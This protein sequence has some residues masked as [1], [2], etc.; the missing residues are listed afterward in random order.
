MTHEQCCNVV[1]R[2]LFAVRVEYESGKVV[3]T[4]GL[5]PETNF[6]LMPKHN[7]YKLVGGEL[8]RSK[9]KR[10]FLRRSPTPG[11]P[12]FEVKL[13]EKS[14]MPLGGDLALVHT[15]AGG[16]VSGLLHLFGEPE[17][18]PKAS[19]PV[20]ELS[21]TAL[22]DPP[23]EVKKLRYM[24]T[25]HEV[26]NRA[27]GVQYP[28]L[29]YSRPEPTYKGLCGAVQIMAGRAVIVGM[30]TMG[31][32]DVDNLCDGASIALSGGQLRAAMAYMRGT[33]FA[34]V[35]AVRM[36]TTVPYTPPSMAQY[37]NVGPL[38]H[39]SA[40]HE[41]G[42]DTTITPLG[43]VPCQTTVSSKTQL[44]ISPYSDLVELHLGEPRQHEPPTTIA[45]KST[46]VRKL[47]EFQGCT[48]L[49]PDLMELAVRDYKERFLALLDAAPLLKDMIR[50]LTL[51]EAING[52]PGCTSFNRMN[53]NT[54]MGW[55]YTGSKRA[56]LQPDPEADDPLIHTFEPEIISEYERLRSRM[57][58]GE[59][60]NLVFKWANKDEPVKIGKL[61]TRVFEAS[62]L[63]LQLLYRTY[64][65][66]LTRAMRLCPIELGCAVG[67]DATSAEWDALVRAAL[68]Y[69]PD[70]AVVGDWVHFDTSQA[71]QEVIA[72]FAA[73]IA[74]A[75]SGFNFTEQDIMVM[76]VIAEET[77][78][79][80]FIV[81]A[82]L[83]IADSATA[84]GG[85]GTVDINNVVNKV[86][87]CV[88]FYAAVLQLPVEKRA[89][90]VPA[91]PPP[92]DGTITT[93][94]GIEL[95]SS[96]AVHLRSS[97]LVEGLRGRFDDYIF[98]TTYG[99]DFVSAPTPSVLEIFNQYTLADFFG[100]QG[101]ELTSP[102]KT[103]FTSAT[104]DWEEVTYLKRWFRYDVELDRY[105]APLEMSSI[106][107][108]MHVVKAKLEYGI[109]FHYAT[110]I[111]NAQRELFQHGR[112]IYERYAP[113]LASLAAALEITHFLQ[114]KGIASYEFWA[115]QYLAKG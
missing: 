21:R 3:E 1:S 69:N 95:S 78:R 65:G 4:Q 112:L 32:A 10:L 73:W 93:L 92:S 72:V 100:A 27:L 33:S 24:A 62:P 38:V 58:Q 35:P 7:F 103:P 47:V 99:D 19:F 28:G 75:S 70:E 89:A 63:L 90:L 51:Q 46:T 31:G 114:Y 67:I 110:L 82:D 20:T 29:L 77:A 76:W 40:L 91:L 23:Y 81:Q 66:G 64:F 41:S 111:D 13:G 25:P 54:A 30:H 96:W 84:S 102:A 5:V 16:T 11:G 71:Y 87:M 17:A 109:D 53:F 55:P 60:V 83:G 36:P 101:K 34:P 15:L 42:D 45:K 37:S 113:R 18:L 49:P 115:A 2:H 44:L 12:N 108:P 56:H 80:M 26:P 105:L 52:I 79:R 50:P 106:F 94:G 59:R 74:V 107:K 68:E 104:T 14:V 98:L 85:S 86:R 48:Q 61:K 88:A 22:G 39:N 43:T 6:L 97:P 8:V 57:E 9:V